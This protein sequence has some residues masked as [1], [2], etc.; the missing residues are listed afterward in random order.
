MGLS[1]SRVLLPLCVLLAACAPA[2][3][4]Q[5]PT[6]VGAAAEGAGN[7]VE[8]TLA[9]RDLAADVWS[10]GGIGAATFELKGG[11]RPAAILL[12]LHLRAL[13]ELRVALGQDVIVVSVASA[14]GH[15]VSQR[16]GAP[17]GAEQELAPGADGWLP[18][19]IIAPTP[20]PAFPLQEGH[21]AVSLPAD[22]LDRAGASI[23]IQWVDFFR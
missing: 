18:V 16:H 23:R 12:R 8:V 10:E 15:A 6:V 7:S 2:P 21:F 19:E 11:P 4:G 14:A 1:V 22:S 20:D 5:G 17:G 3:T 9:G 13:E